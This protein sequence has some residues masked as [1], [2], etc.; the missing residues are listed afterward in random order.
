MASAIWPVGLPQAPLLAAYSQRDEKRVVRFTTDTGP[1]I[2][3]ARSAAIVERCSIGLLL[4]GAQV[5]LLKTFFRSTVAAGALPFQWRHHQSGNLIDYRFLSEPEFKPRAPRQSGTE[6]WSVTFELETMP[7]TE[8]IGEVEPPL[9]PI[10]MPGGGDWFSMVHVEDIDESAV[11]VGASEH[12]IPREADAAEPVFLLELLSGAGSGHRFGEGED[13]SDPDGIDGLGQ[14][15]GLVLS[16]SG[17][18]GGIGVD[19]G[20]IP[21]G[22]VS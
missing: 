5:A 4:T 19:V 6:L 14:T 12:F 22:G 16:S 8:I 13:P 3:R 11:G 18:G 2:V 20:V 21:G 17:G 7:G 15:D 1:A 9:E 10:Y